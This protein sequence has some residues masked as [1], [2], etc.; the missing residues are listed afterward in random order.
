M[1]GDAV[2]SRVGCD[3]SGRVVSAL[4]GRVNLISVAMES[5]ELLRGCCSGVNEESRLGGGWVWQGRQG[6]VLNPCH[7]ALP[8][9]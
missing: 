6:L 2:M 7:L 3:D 4:V 8:Q 9:E 5:W 1:F